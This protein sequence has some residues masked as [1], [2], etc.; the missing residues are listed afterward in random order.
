MK[1]TGKKEL[2]RRKEPSDS[3]KSGCY[4][5]DVAKYSET[6]HQTKTRVVL[7]RVPDPKGGG[8]GVLPKGEGSSRKAK[9]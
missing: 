6:D 3:S 1:I 2:I 8:G 7:Y 4:N 5:V 9:S